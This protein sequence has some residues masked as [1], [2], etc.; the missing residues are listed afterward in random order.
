MSR[1]K[2]LMAQHQPRRIWKS[3]I[4]ACTC[5]TEWRKAADQITHAAQAIGVRKQREKNEET[6]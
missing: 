6:R 1:V 5:G 2:A 3:D 4:Y